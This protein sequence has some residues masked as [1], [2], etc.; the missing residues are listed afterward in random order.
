MT[1]LRTLAS[2]VAIGLAAMGILAFAALKFQPVPAAPDAPEA[3]I[4]KRAKGSVSS[5]TRLPAEKP[6]L[7]APTDA[8]DDAAGSVMVAS[9]G[10]DPE[11]VRSV[12]RGAVQN[13]LEC[14]A[15][16]PSVTL[17]LSIDVACTGR[18][19]K[20]NV[21]DDGGASLEVQGCVKD[22]LRT[23]S[24]PAHALPDGDTFEYPLAYS[25]L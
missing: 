23:A 9:A 6:C 12:M 22:A 1:A 2:F 20:V 18:V 17:W 7:A 19:S 25:A 8:A 24:F 11:A 13:T 3:A 21:D 16:A 14:F 15:G 5:L 10:L 4:S